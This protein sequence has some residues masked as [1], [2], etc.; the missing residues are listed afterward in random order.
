LKYECTVAE[1]GKAYLYF[2]S[3]KKHL[4]VAHPEKYKA[5]LADNKRNIL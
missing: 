1:C 5:M 4:K 2:S 3:L